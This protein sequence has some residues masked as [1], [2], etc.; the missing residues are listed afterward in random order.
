VQRSESV[1]KIAPAIIAMQGQIE[2]ATKGGENPHFRSKYSTLDE[3]WAAAKAALQ[4]NGLAVLQSYLPTDGQGV[5]IETTLLHSSG[6]W[7]SGTLRMPAVKNDPQ[8]F[9]SACT[10]GRRYSLSAMLGIC[11]EVDDDAEAAMKSSRKPPQAS[12]APDDTGLG[13]LI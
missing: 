4:A 2:G 3:V 9:G 1:T 13:D 8:A 6:E 12:D 7:V 5:E 11:S 10:Y